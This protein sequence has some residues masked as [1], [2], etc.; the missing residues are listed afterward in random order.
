MWNHAPEMWAA[1]RQMSIVSPDLDEQG[2]GDL[3]AYF[4]SVRFFE[5]VGDAARGRAAFE[6]KGCSRCHGIVRQKRPAAKPVMQWESAF[7]PIALASAMWNHGVG[8]AADFASLRLKWPQLTSQD[9]TDIVIYSQAQ[10]QARGPSLHIEISSGAEG[11]ALFLAR[12]CASCH[13]GIPALT[14]RLKGKTL[15]DIAAAMWNHQPKMAPAAPLLTPTE[16]RGLASYL[17]A[18]GFFQDSGD[19]VAGRRVF[20]SKNCG[21]CHNDHSNAALNLNGRVFSGITLVSALWHHGPPILDQ[22]K[23]KGFAWPQ[24]E[25][26][27]M[28]NLIAFLN[29]QR[30]E[31]SK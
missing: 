21:T 26:R 7:E 4:Y 6:S 16:M 1:M 14:E 28:S 17:W 25:A 13:T 2:A 19:A 11:E 3:F 23:A 24:F 5:K 9:L 29:S 22:M 27:E 8:I 20:A 12:G 18:T 10:A 15:T 31:N 30:R